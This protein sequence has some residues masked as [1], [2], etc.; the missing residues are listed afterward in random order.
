MLGLGTDDRGL[1]RIIVSR[2]ELDLLNIK[3]KYY[4]KF[5]RTL[6]AAVKSETSGDYRKLL[7]LILG[8]NVFDPDQEA[9]VG[10]LFFLS[11]F[12]SILVSLN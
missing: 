3:T 9:K 6:E 10:P 7:L 8:S 11:F 12:L 5:G 1:I 4:K 2:S